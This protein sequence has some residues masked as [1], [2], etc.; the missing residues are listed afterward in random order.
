MDFAC[1]IISQYRGWEKVREPSAIWYFLPQK[2][3]R[4]LSSESE[5]GIVPLALSDAQL[6]LS[7]F[8]TVGSFLEIL[9]S[10]YHSRICRS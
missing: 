9:P 7:H 5:S 3:S 2:H 4:S 8:S 10:K 6:S 1:G